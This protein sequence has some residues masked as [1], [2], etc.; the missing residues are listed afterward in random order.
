MI[1]YLRVIQ[2]NR[3]CRMSNSHSKYV[4]YNTNYVCSYLDSDVFIETDNV[5]DDDRDFIRNCI[6][7]QDML[8]IFELDDFEP[9]AINSS[10]ESIYELIKYNLK[11]DEIIKHVGDG[12]GLM[13]LTILFSY[14]YLYLTHPCICKYIETQEVNTTELEK[15]ILS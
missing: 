11:F 9:V 12:D 1:K 10:I 8:N 3:Y 15:I 6:Y 7:R 4:K 2:Y 5:S 14:D 13:G